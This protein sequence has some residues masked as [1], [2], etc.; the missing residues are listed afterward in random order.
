MGASFTVRYGGGAGA[1]SREVVEV[2][3]GRYV[4]V[5]GGGMTPGHPRCEKDRREVDVS[6]SLFPE[7]PLF[8]AD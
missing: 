5:C 4:C 6:V 1:R 7:V 2:A 8:G 3:A